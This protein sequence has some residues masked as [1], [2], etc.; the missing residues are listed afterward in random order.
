MASKF[1]IVRRVKGDPVAKFTRAGAE[2][3]RAMKST[4]S[5]TAKTIESVSVA[6]APVYNSAKYPHFAHMQHAIMSTMFPGRLKRSI[7]VSQI[8]HFSRF[9]T[10]ALVAATGYAIYIEKGFRHYLAKR[11]ICGRFFMRSSVRSVM[12]SMIDWVF[13][14]ACDSVLEK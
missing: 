2:F 4:L 11:W 1:I 3:P 10:F 9:F 14:F 7:K 6:T 13:G 5:I 12:G 8:F